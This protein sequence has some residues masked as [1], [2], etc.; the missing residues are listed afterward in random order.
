MNAPGTRA[1]IGQ[2]GQLPAEAVTAAA[3]AIHD[4]SLRS[5]DGRDMC[6]EAVW[7]EDTMREAYL[8]A[9]AA[10][11]AALP[12]L[13]AAAAERERIARWLDTRAA[14]MEDET[15]AWMIQQ[16]AKTIRAW[17]TG[18]D[19]R[20]MADAIADYRRAHRLDVT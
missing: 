9:E 7:H 17:P 16:A 8:T 5:P 4:V 13:E 6:P 1:V 15:T 3:D 20:N 12:H 11:K 19:D 10:L 18:E 2:P 14:S